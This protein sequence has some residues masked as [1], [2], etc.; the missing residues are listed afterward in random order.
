MIGVLEDLEQ[1]IDDLKYQNQELAGKL[2]QE[3]KNKKGGG[4]NNSDLAE[5]NARLL[6]ELE[7]SQALAAQYKEKLSLLRVEYKKLLQQKK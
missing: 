7:E 4:S 6:E 3:K 1:E 2:E 5:E